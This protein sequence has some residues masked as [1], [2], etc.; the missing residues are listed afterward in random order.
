VSLL[1]HFIGTSVLLVGN[2][3]DLAENGMMRATLVGGYTTM[4]PSLDEI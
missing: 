4:C 3:A 2:E 1:D